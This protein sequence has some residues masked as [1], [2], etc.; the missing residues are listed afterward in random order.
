VRLTTE[1]RRIGHGEKEVYTELRRV[2]ML[3]ATEL[4]GFILG[5]FNWIVYLD[6][7]PSPIW[8]GS[9]EGEVP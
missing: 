4:G 2:L 1:R 5:P 7:S 8:R 9:G 6:S 3:R